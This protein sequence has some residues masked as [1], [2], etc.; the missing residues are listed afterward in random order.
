MQVKTLTINGLN[1]AFPFRRCCGGW[2][3][4]VAEQCGFRL[5]GTQL[6]KVGRARR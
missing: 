6:D 1:L 3:P 2:R 5:G 4:L